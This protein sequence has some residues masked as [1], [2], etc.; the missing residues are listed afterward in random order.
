MR[1]TDRETRPATIDERDVD[2]LTER[3][4]ERF[5]RIVAGPLGSKLRVRS[6]ERHWIG[7]EESGD[8]AA[9][10]VP[11]GPLLCE[12]R[13]SS[14]SM[15]DGFVRHAAPELLE[16]G[17]SIARRVAGNERRVDSPNRRPDD[18]VRLDAG[19]V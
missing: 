3:L 9:Q 11:V 16:A 4:P 10:R 14:R 7:F 6:P 2:Q 15:P 1:R 19:L 17:Q 12:L 18:P 13:P 8:A 5:R